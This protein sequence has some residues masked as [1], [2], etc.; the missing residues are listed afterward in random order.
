VKFKKQLNVRNWVVLRQSAFRDVGGRSRP[1]LDRYSAAISRP[2]GGRLATMSATEEQP[3]MQIRNAELRFLRGKS[4]VAAFFQMK[5]H[6]TALPACLNRSLANGY[7]C[8][9]NEV[10]QIAIE[11]LRPLLKRRMPYIRIFNRTCIRQHV[12]QLLQF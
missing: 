12:H 3:S 7:L 9:A 6:D 4:V 5:I 2:N 10:E 1:S 11:P 8:Y